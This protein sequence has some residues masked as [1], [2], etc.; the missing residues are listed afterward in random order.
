M[1]VRHDAASDRAPGL[2]REKG[3]RLE[4]IGAWILGIIGAVG[5]FMGLFILFAGEEQSVGIGG[6]LSWKVGEIPIAWPYGLLIGG[7]VLLL[8]AAWLYRLGVVAARAGGHLAS[9]A[10]TDLVLH[11][12]AFVVVN[13]FLWLQDIATGGGLDYAYWITIPWGAGLAIHA[14]SYILGRRGRQA[15]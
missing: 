4:T 6:D 3:S 2:G 14:G 9:R 8:A 5:A 10:L 11:G 15:A 13:A 1:T 7:L 12:T